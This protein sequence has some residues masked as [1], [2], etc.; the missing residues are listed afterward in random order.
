M[1]KTIKNFFFA[2][3]H[4]ILLVVLLFVSLSFLPLNKGSKLTNIKRY[5]FGTFSFLSVGL[6]KIADIFKDQEEILKLKELN[7][8][9]MLENNLLRNYALENS[10]LKS[11][12]NYKDTSGSNLIAA[13]VISKLVSSVQGNLIINVGE[14]DSVIIGMPVINERGLIGIV[15]E[16]SDNYSVV[17][18]IQN[19]DFKLTVEIQRSRFKSIMNWNGKQLYLSNVPT[20]ADIKVG[21]RIVSSSFSTFLPPSIPVGVVTSMEQT[22]SGLLGEVY[23]E[24][25][26]EFS[27]IK[28]LFVLQVIKSIE[29]EGIELNF[30]K[31]E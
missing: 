27:S 22:V 19:I 17:R 10:E 31:M 2:F 8:R 23:I 4:Y 20:T 26:V 30:L 16:T 12:L 11:L 25:F 7:A 21:D 9:L 13:S 29:L 6:E 15:K 28:N 3:K 5:A 24:P 18:T 1:W 14:S